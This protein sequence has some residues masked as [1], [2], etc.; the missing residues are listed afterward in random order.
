MWMPLVVFLIIIIINI[1]II[2]SH[3][4]PLASL[5]VTAG[6]GAGQSYGRGGGDGG[7]GAGGVARSWGGCDEGPPLQPH[8][9][10]LGV[11]ALV[12]R[13]RPQE[14]RVREV[15]DLLVRHHAP[16]PRRRAPRS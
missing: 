12:V 6:L 11:V 10:H 13:G 16:A 4:D 7:G 1:N 15:E 2:N 3:Q 9:R 8:H 5:K 14:P